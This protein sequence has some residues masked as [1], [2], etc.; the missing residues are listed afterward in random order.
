MTT[1]LKEDLDIVL[2]TQNN[3][4]DCISTGEGVVLESIGTQTDTIEGAT[5]TYWN[6]LWL[7]PRKFQS[8]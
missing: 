8:I 3:D 1:H 4:F 7:S 6:I 5:L 2:I